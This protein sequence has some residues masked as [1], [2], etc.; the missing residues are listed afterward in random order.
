MS[1]DLK[2]VG[3]YGTGSDGDFTNTSYYNV[4][5]PVV[6]G[7]DYTLKATDTG[8]DRI[9]EKCEVLLICIQSTQ[10]ILF[11]ITTGSALTNCTVNTR[12]YP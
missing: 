4:S 6:F 7:S 9:V 11:D 3:G 12:W 10:A 2:E 1:F 5:V 8:F